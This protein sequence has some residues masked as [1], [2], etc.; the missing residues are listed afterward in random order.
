MI[1]D[2]FFFSLYL[3]NK[4]H[5]FVNNKIFNEVIYQN[6]SIP[7]GAMAALTMRRSSIA[8]IA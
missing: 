4:I 2:K 8:F 1:T 6:Q 7:F 5:L 3:Y